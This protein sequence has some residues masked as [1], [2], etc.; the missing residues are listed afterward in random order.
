MI[1]DKIKI[2]VHVINV[3]LTK[4]FHGLQKFLIEFVLFLYFVAN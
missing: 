2:K 3:I 4:S 1:N